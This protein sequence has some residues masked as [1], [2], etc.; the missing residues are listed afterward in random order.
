MNFRPIS[1][2]S[3][4]CKILEKKIFMHLMEYLEDKFLISDKQFDFRSAH[5]T[6]DQLLLT[7]ND[8]SHSIDNGRITD[9][10]FLTTLKHLTK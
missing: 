8:I 2:T 10:V 3:V 4:P 7:Y 5:C 1:L 9:F 6:S